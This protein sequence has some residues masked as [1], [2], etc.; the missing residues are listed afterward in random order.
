MSKNV[1]G[2]TGSD[3]SKQVTSIHATENILWYQCLNTILFTDN[4]TV[5]ICIYVE[6]QI[7]VYMYHD[8]YLINGILLLNI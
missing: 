1:A 7:R 4:Y 5:T 2:M 6:Y 8:D 3:Y